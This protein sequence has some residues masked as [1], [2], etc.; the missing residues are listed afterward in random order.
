MSA[1]P[2]K[3]SQ[4]HKSQ[5]TNHKHITKQHE[6]NK[7]LKVTQ[8]QI[9]CYIFFN[10]SY[11]SSFFSFLIDGCLLVLPSF[12]RGFEDLRGAAEE[13]F[14]SLRPLVLSLRGF[15]EDFGDFSLDAEDFLGGAKDLSL[16]PDGFLAFSFSPL[17]RELLSLR[18]FGGDFLPLFAFALALPSLIDILSMLQEKYKITH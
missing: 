7:W 14:F 10:R 11:L 2:T 4:N 12:G 5:I 15:G 18:V 6:S 9:I 17:T 3:S 16:D 1:T 13:S 8:R